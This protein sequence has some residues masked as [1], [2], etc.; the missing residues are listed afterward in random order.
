V[1]LIAKN[2]VRLVEK[3]VKEALNDAFS[4]ELAQLSKLIDPKTLMG[5]E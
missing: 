4:K 2:D 5:S 3:S 1:K